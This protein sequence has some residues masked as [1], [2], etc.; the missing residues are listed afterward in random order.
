MFF[1]NWDEAEQTHFY[2][3][4]ENTIKSRLQKMWIKLR[5]DKQMLLFAS[6]YIPF[7]S[8]SRDNA[9]ATLILFFVTSKPDVYLNLIQQTI[10]ST[11]EY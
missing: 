9:W 4:I 5:D 6:I 11:K 3:E 7:S 8:I 10:E 2:F 1:W